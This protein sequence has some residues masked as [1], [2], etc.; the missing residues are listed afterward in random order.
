MK[1]FIKYNICGSKPNLK[2]EGRKHFFQVGVL[3]MDSDGEKGT[4]TIDSLPV[5]FNGK[6]SVFIPSEVKG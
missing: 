2:E 6:L 5:N 3:I 1:N 4:I